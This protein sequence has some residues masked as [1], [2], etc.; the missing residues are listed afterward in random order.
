[1]SLS[2]QTQQLQ[3]L[4]TTSHL[5]ELPSIKDLYQTLIDALTEHNHLY[6]VQETP[7]IS[8]TE[9]DQL[10]DFLKRIEEEFPYLISSNSPTQSLIG[11][12]ADEFKKADHKVPLLS[13]ENSYNAS[14]LFDFDERVKKILNKQGISDYQYRVEPKYDGVSV[15]LI[16]QEGEL[17]KAITRGDG[18]TGEDITTNV[19]TIKNLP[20]QLDNV[21]AFLSVRG[22][23][24]M[25]KSVWKTLNLQR[26]QEGKEIFANTR[27][28]TAGSIKL[29]DSGEVAKRNLSC[30]VYDV[31]YAENAE[32]EPIDYLL[33][34]VSLPQVDL[35]KPPTDMHGVEAI[36]LDPTVK[37]FLDEQDFD[38]D[39]LVI[40]VVNQNGERHLLGTTHHHPR[41]GIAYKFPAEQTSTQILSVNFQVG[42]NGTLTPVAQLQPVKLSGAEISRVSLHNV[43]FIRNKDI[44]KSDFI[45]IQRSGEVIPYVIGVVKERRTGNETP[46]EAP[47]FCP[48]CQ[49]PT[50]H[51]GVFYYC[52]NPN[53]P[54]QLKE[55]IRYFVS[56]DCMDIQGIGEGIIDVLVDKGIFR[57][58]A[59][60]Y[61]LERSELRILLRK[62]PGFGDKR[63]YDLMKQVK[64][65]KRQPL[66]R[67]INAL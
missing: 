58:V 3:K 27:N 11:Q 1:M 41:W 52:A 32:G 61:Q 65:S 5:T 63:I 10:F 23:I 24:M 9:Y 25:P 44:K 21:P 18:I 43:D 54:A 56:K 12:V 38:F 35:H 48:V 36:C 64:A 17:I 20:K 46:I 4:S 50:T 42:R 49:S 60:I 30:F 66:W 59:D 14:D 31:L 19:K 57:S 33:K 16:Y 28:A 47:L 39:G 29:L 13:L 51:I 45:W 37:T 6:Y 2:E 34:D 62:F 8:D 22:E 40:K 55:K 53:C 67:M 26:E 15:E 7:I